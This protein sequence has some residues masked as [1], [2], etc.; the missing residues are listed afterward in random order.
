MGSSKC[1]HFQEGFRGL[2]APGVRDQQLELVWVDCGQSDEY[3]GE[4]VVMRLGEEFGRVERE[5]RILFVE[6]GDAHGD[7]VGSR[8]TGL[9]GLAALVPGPDEA[10]ELASV[11]DGE[12]EAVG[13]LGCV[14][15]GE[16]DA[17]DVVLGGHCG[18]AILRGASGLSAQGEGVQRDGLSSALYDCD[19]ILPR[20]T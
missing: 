20:V 19:E 16:G 9:L 2:K 4:A 14:G 7:D 6:V 11:E 18:G 5:Q 8:D 12:G 13:R 10:F 15:E 17:A 1:H 3:G